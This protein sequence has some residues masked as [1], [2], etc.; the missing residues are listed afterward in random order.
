MEPSNLEQ[1]PL[2][3]FIDPNEIS[4]IQPVINPG[5]FPI[6]IKPAEDS[7]FTKRIKKE[8]ALQQ[9]ATKKPY[10][11]SATDTGLFF[12]C[13]EFFGTDLE[14]MLGV[15]KGKSIRQ[16]SRKLHKERKRNQ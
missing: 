5:E 12:K 13:I 15:F 4:I 11:W 9:K 8:N 1:I 3:E 10:K 16:L 2:I 14:M 7:V 6:E